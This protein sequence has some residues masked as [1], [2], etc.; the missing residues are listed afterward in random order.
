MGGESS[1]GSLSRAP[2]ATCH[3]PSQRLRVPTPSPRAWVSAD[4]SGGRG[5]HSRSGHRGYS[6]KRRTFSGIQAT[7]TVRPSN[8]PAQGRWEGAP[9]QPASKS[10]EQLHA[11]PKLGTTQT[12]SS[13]CGLPR[14]SR[15]PAALS[16][17]LSV[18]GAGRRAGPQK[19]A[20]AA[21]APV[22][23]NAG[24]TWGSGQGPETEELLVCPRTCEQTVGAA[25]ETL[26][27][28]LPREESQ[29]LSEK[30]P[31]THWP[32]AQARPQLWF[33]MHRKSKR[34]PRTLNPVNI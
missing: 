17:V 23:L 30:V 20:P 8:A 3:A 28:Q 33:Q 24:S 10:S 26:M 5:A 21:P 2:P 6:G 12:P 11:G 18:H 14:R 25:P 29:G 15:N 16:A 22:A 4:D 19:A 7:L 13:R 34:R 31:L 1:L 27:T 9:Q 32:G